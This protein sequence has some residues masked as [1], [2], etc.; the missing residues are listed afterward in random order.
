MPKSNDSSHSRKK[1]GPCPP[2]YQLK[3]VEGQWTCVSEEGDIIPTNTKAPSNPVINPCPPGYK[4]IQRDGRWMCQNVDN[5]HIASP[6]H[7]RTKPRLKK[8]DGG[9]DPGGFVDIVLPKV[10]PPQNP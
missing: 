4:L 7:A 3:Q 6:D 1:L 10:A 8:K 9:S 2:G 5:G